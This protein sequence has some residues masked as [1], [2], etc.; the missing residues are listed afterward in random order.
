[1]GSENKIERHFELTA[2]MEGRE[3]ANYVASNVFISAIERKLTLEDT[4][5]GLTFAKD[6]MEELIV[7]FLEKNE[8]VGQSFQR[9]RNI[10][11]DNYM[12]VLNLRLSAIKERLDNGGGPAGTG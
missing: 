6:N 4:M 1:M 12:E 7:S 10:F 3:I 2:I 9:N 11:T 5:E 8:A